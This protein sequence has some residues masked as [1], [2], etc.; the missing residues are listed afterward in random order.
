[1][2]YL[3]HLEVLWDYMQLHQNPQK[4]DVILGFGNF[5]TNIARRAS[6]LY[7]AGYASKIL[8][9]G[10]LGRN[11]LGLL[12]EPEARRFF[13]ISLDMG[14]PEK[15]ILLEEKSR[16]TAE[17]ILFS[18]ELLEAKNIPHRCIL[19][20]H[21]PFMERR[22]CAAIGVYWPEVSF[23][24]TSPPI[25]LSKYLA[26]SIA[27]GITENAAV[28]VIVG[29]F[30]RIELYAKKGWQIPQQIPPHAWAA[31]HALVALGFDQQ[32]AK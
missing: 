32:L 9:T 5:N 6:E 29:D 26:D 18:K 15:D 24:V 30:Q 25:T 31:Y 8:F 1:M 27:Q 11:T 4:A 19:G 17:N 13:R 28:S 22:I 21:Q 7:L 12:S 10:G 20:I 23:S 14:V 2:D 16:N 3:S